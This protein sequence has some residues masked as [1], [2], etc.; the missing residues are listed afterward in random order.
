[1]GNVL[2]RCVPIQSKEPMHGKTKTQNDSSFIKHP[3][4]SSVDFFEEYISI[5]GVIDFQIIKL[6]CL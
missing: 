3:P 6:T 1:M 4:F 5:R 2:S